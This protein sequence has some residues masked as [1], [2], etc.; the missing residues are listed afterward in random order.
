MHVASTR[1]RGGR[2][3]EGCFR[4]LSGLMT[5]LRGTRISFQGISTSSDAQVCSSL[6]GRISIGF[7]RVRSV[8]GISTE[9]SQVSGSSNVLP[10]ISVMSKSRHGNVIA[11]FCFSLLM[12]FVSASSISSSISAAD[13]VVS[14]R[15]F[16]AVD[17]AM[18]FQG[19]S[20]IES[21]ITD[22]SENSWRRVC[23]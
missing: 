20:T 2:L 23:M 18:S 21:H 11:N 1:G 12:V 8:H 14:G 10:T 22:L 3:D 6:D 5:M 17:R 9:E 19:S 16:I 7:S 4:F 13:K 15:I